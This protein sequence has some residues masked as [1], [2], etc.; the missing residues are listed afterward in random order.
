MDNI[1]ITFESGKKYA[2]I[3]KSG[4]GKSTLMRLLLLHYQSTEGSIS[5]GDDRIEDIELKYLRK[6]IKYVSAESKLFEGSIIDNILFESTKS[7]SDPTVKEI[8]NGCSLI[9]VLNTLPGG[10]YSRISEGGIELSSGQ[11]QR[12]ILAQALLSEPEILILD[13]ATGHLDKESENMVFRFI[14]DYERDITCICVLHNLELV[15][16]CDRIVVM[17]QGKIAKIDI[18]V[19]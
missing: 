5:I 2:L 11:R 19:V 16:L 10:I 17:E 15:N 4:C 9:E 12:I 7:E 18:K 6:K 8:I 13:E 14:L 3:G 1:N